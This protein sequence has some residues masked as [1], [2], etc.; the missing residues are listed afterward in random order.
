YFNPNSGVPQKSSTHINSWTLMAKAA[1]LVYDPE[2][3]PAIGMPASIIKLLFGRT[4]E[5]QRENLKDYFYSL[6]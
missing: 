2:V 3:E 6:D 1:D 4:M 5:S